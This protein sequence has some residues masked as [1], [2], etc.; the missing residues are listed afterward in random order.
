MKSA[1]TKAD[2]VANSSQADKTKGHTKEVIGSARQKV[3]DL[4]GS[5][6]MEAKGHA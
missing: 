4:V 5:D 1:D 3:G 2:E 6:E